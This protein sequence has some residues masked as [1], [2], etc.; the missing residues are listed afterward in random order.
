MLKDEYQILEGRL[1][2][3]AP[4]I[5]KSDIL[6]AVANRCLFLLWMQQIRL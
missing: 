1:L 2:G 5:T 3:V 4:G 6:D